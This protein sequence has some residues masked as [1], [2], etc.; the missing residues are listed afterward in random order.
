[1]HGFVPV[2]PDEELSLCK[3]QAEAPVAPLGKALD[4]V[5]KNKSDGDSGMSIYMH[6]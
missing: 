3:L 5:D 1:M 2:D 4:V 6:K